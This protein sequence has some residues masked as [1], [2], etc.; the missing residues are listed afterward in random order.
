MSVPYINY[1]I[2]FAYIFQI[3]KTF[4]R[5]NNILFFKNIYFK[6]EKEWILVWV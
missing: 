1:I 3:M 2:Q 5:E 6:F 4:I